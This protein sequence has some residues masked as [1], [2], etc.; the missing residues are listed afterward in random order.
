VL[1]EAKGVMR[2]PVIL[3]MLMLAAW[4]IHTARA[5]TS[6]ATS[7]WMA[8]TTYTDATAI[9]PGTLVTYKVYL[10]P[11]GKEVYWNSTVATTIDFAGPAPGAI[12]CI[13]VTANVAGVESD[14]TPESCVLGPTVPVVK[15]PAAPKSV[16]IA[17]K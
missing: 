9:V 10:G 1:H 8:V 11:P 12:G 15:K 7:T 2:I 5:Q 13:V 4:A 16:T 3:G 14:K 17:L 6:T